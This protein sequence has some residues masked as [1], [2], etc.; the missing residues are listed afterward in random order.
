MAR[1][2]QITRVEIH[3]YAYEV[4][5]L[6]VDYNGFNSVYQPGARARL[7]GHVITI[8]TDVGVTGEYA[9]GMATGYAQVP[10]AAAY[11]LGKNPLRRELIYND[12]KR[13]LRKEDRLGIGPIDTA[14]WDLAGK[15]YDAPV[16]ELLGGY[17]T[18]L[19]AYASTYHGDEN[20]GLS[21]PEQF[22]EFAV[23][24]REMGYRAF[25]IHGWGTGPIRREVDTVLATRKAVPDMDLMLDPACEYN[26]WADTL[27]VGHACDE[28]R[29]F[30]LEDPYKDGG[31]SAFGHRKLRQIIKTPI[32]IGEHIRGH[33]LHVDNIVADG[34]DYVRADADYDGGITGLMKIAH[35][36][37]GFGLDVEI[38]APGPEHRHCMAAIR[39]TNY[40][41]LG[42]VH[43]RVK[44]TKPPIYACGYSDELDAIDANGQVPVPQGPGLGVT[45]D[46]DWVNKNRVGHV[47]YE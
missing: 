26:T 14:L 34:T 13:A 21:T 39:N 43:P 33:E 8:A 24:C 32:L 11:L 4:R 19:P 44:T 10:K 35:S 38:H 28:A 37:E 40:Y 18:T 20:G 23:Q 46:W 47:V 41:E 25:K 30:W 15:L 6:G 9:G 12:L 3:E 27:K 36:A 7:T 1:S 17:R 29:Y 2:P 22:A 16:Y 31:I 5:E 45:I 42:L